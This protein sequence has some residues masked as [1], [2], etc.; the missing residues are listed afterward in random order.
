MMGFKTIITNALTLLGAIL[1]TKGVNFG[2][3]QIAQIVAAAGTII[4]IV[5]PIA[6]TVFHMMSKTKLVPT[7]VTPPLPT[8]TG[9]AS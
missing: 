5:G 7:P 2:S 1:A 8:L 6:S 9:P 4:T 3:D